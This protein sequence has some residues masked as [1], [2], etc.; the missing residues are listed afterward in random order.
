[1][2]RRDPK[3]NYRSKCIYH[4]TLSKAAGVP[5]F[6][7]IQGVFSTDGRLIGAKSLNYPLG[8]VIRNHLHDISRLNTS[9]KIWQYVIMPDHVHFI[10]FAK[11]YL[12]EHVGCYISR[13]KINIL[14]DARRYLNLNISSGIFQ[15]DYYDRILRPYQSADVIFQYI[16]SNPYRLLIRRLNPGYFRRINSLTVNGSKWRAYGNPH[17]LANPFK[18]N[19]IVHRADSEE[20]RDLKLNQA[21][22]FAL[23][24]GV[25]VSPFIA[26]AEKKI[27]DACLN[28]E[29]KIIVLTNDAFTDRYKPSGRLFELC[30]KGRLLILSPTETIPLNRQCCKY[31]NET[32]LRLAEMPLA[33]MT[34]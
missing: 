30:E 20:I 25:I 13:L 26:D 23:N 32:A 12:P 34:E 33:D 28:V 15:E 5:D 2:A 9:L 14:N 1:M 11:S 10:L 19:V 31:L 7:Q 3:H 4:I 21:L 17:L 24:G 6:S 27:R 16:R 18:I 29:G 8:N 22:Y